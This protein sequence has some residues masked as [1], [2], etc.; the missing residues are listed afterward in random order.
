MRRRVPTWLWEGIETNCSSI[1]RGPASRSFPPAASR[2][3]RTS[4]RLWTWTPRSTRG[5]GASPP[6]TLSNTHP[7]TK[8]RGMVSPV[9]EKANV[10]TMKPLIQKTVDDLLTS[11][12]E[13]GCRKP[14]DLVESFS[15]PLPS[16]VSSPRGSLAHCDEKRTDLGERSSTP[17]SASPRRTLSTSRTKTPP[18]QTAARRPQRHK[19]QTS[20]QAPSCPTQTHTPRA[21]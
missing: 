20:T 21:R 17:S 11:M 1:A 18:A 16:Y 6:G 10:E 13:A 7:L 5:R 14:V 8:S 2:P 15:L 19:T 9:F 12:I 4:P 3:R